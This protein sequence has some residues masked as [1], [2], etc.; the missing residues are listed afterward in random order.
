VYTPLLILP[1]PNVFGD[2]ENVR[3]AEPGAD[4]QML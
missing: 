3:P 2:K 4:C 1:D